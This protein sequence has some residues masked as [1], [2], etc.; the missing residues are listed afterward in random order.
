MNV[1]SKPTKTARIT[2]GLLLAL[3][4]AIALL[5]SPSEAVAD[6]KQRQKALSIGD[7]IVVLQRKPFLRK[8]R[9]EFE[10][11]FRASF[12][13]SLVQQISGG[14]TINYHINEMLFIGLLGSW[15]DWRFISTDSNS[16]TDIY[17]RTIDATDSIP[18]TSVINA[19]A[20]LDIGYV[21]IYGKMTLFGVGVVHWDLSLKIGG[22]A[23]HA[24][25]AGFGGGGWVAASQR[26]FLT[27]WLSL[28]TEVRGIF[29]GDNLSDDPDAGSSFYQ[30]WVAGV[31]IAFW[32][33]FGFEY[34]D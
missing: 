8:G 17:E 20:G 23:V 34:K 15:Q 10:P 27:D 3:S 21:P 5:G 1:I 31:G 25:S 7:R 11:N 29:Y 4:T 2:M 22:G 32:A 13:D 9:V 14:L 19:Y 26:F 24:R 12:N 30:Q 33:P 6:E 16:Y 18:R 28:N